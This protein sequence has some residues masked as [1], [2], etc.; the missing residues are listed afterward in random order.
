MKRKYT[1]PNMRIVP[2]LG[3]VVMMLK[4]SNTVKKFQSGGDINI[5]SDEDDD[6]S[7]SREDIFIGDDED[8]E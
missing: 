8:W 1:T 5:G 7:S 2:L 4:G 6:V 3:P